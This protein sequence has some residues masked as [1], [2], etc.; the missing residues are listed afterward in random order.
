MDNLV[1][2]VT[3]SYNSEKYILETYNSIKNQTYRNWEWI[4]ID[5]CS[6]DR[7]VEIIKKE[8][9]KD[10]HVKLIINEKNIKAAASRN[11]G[12]EIS[13]GDYITFI[14][15]DDLWGNIFLEKQL[16]LLN[17]EKAHVVFSSYR[18]VSEDLKTNLGD[19]IVPE[20]ITYKDLLK[21]NYM[22]CLTTVYKKNRFS[23]LR[24]NESLKMHEDYVM[25]L[26]LLEKE[27]IAYAN[28]KVL[29]FY[30]IR[31]NSTSRNKL[32]NL[33]YMYF[34]LRKIKKFSKYKS[35]NILLNYI[36]Y[37][38]KKNKEIIKNSLNLFE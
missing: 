17:K 12:I 30:R 21:T 37:G 27:K 3:P 2:I 22:S 18:R 10:N 13:K 1:S 15:S 19:Y 34:V 5:D 8:I 20:K 24:F 31:E 29:A 33:F 26:N 32:K 16:N 9:L 6:S 14:D 7:T 4:I 28:K 35:I 36:Y 23:S 11:K 38:I 25:W